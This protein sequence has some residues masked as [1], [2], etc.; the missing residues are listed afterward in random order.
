MMKVQEAEGKRQEAEGKRQEAE[1][2]CSRSIGSNSPGYCYT[3]A[4]VPSNKKCPSKSLDTRKSLVFYRVIDL[5]MG[6]RALSDY[7][8]AALSTCRFVG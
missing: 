3:I 1:G 2:C 4:F 8:S 6:N 5:I 7:A